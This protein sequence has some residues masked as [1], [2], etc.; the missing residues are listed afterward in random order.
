MVS[1]APPVGRRCNC[2]CNS[3]NNITRLRL[4][5][6]AERGLTNRWRCHF[7]RCTE[8]YQSYGYLPP[9]N[10]YR[11]AALVIS[12]SPISHTTGH[13]T[14]RYSVFSQTPPNCSD[15]WFSKKAF[16]GCCFLTADSLLL[17]TSSYRGHKS[18]TTPSVQNLCSV[19][20]SA[21]GGHLSVCRFHF[22]DVLENASNHSKNR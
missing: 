6:A 17:F 20:D 13:I 8:D 22:T 12:I 19:R 2:F 3:L 1:Y 16:K 15:Y 11:K 21:L 14:H 7:M 18:S 4:S 10:F 9:M 5:A